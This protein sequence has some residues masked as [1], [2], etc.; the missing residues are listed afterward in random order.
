[1]ESLL[2]MPLYLQQPSTKEKNPHICS[3]MYTKNLYLVKILK[4]RFLLF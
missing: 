3:E 2:D 1:M 4:L